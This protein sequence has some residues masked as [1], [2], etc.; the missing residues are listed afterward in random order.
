MIGERIQNYEV[1][2]LLGEGGMGAVYV[3]KHPVIDRKVAIK[4]LRRELAT[5]KAL[6]ERFINEARAANVI[7]HPNIVEIQD[8]GT[9]PDGLPYIIMELLAGESLAQRLDRVGRLG[10]EQAIHFAVQATSAL[11]AA[12]AE[13]IVHRDLKPDNLFLSPVSPATA[14]AREVLKVLDFG[15]AKV[16]RDVSSSKLTSTGSLM[17]TPTYMSPEQCRGIPG[18]IDHRTDIYAMGAIIYQMLCGRPPFVSEG[19]GDL[20]IMHLTQAPAPLRSLNPNVPEHVERAVLAALEKDKAA[21]PQTMDALQ[22]MLLAGD[23]TDEA[24]GE[25]AFAATM[26]PPDPGSFV[27]GSNPFANLRRGGTNPGAGG[28]SGTIVGIGG[29]PAKTPSTPA[30]PALQTSAKV[31]TT[32]S[33]STG[34]VLTAAG[35]DDDALDALGAS[36]A[37]RKRS[38][39]IGGAAAGLVAVVAVVGIASRGKDEGAKAGAAATQGAPA[40][41]SAGPITTPS[42]P[43]SAAAVAPPAPAAA[44]SEAP[45]PAAQPAAPEV[46][47]AAATP[48]AAAPP[49]QEP[50][51]SEAGSR[52]SRGKKG[53]SADRAPAAKAAAPVVA[54]KPTAAP[55]V[56]P[57]PVAAP[58][59]KP[60]PAPASPAETAKKAKK[61]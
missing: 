50:A 51:R 3:G 16:K 9:L 48:P 25:A 13:G 30:A 53:R 60:G 10:V 31:P 45:K 49:Q 17:G 6:I 34:Q 37:K 11:A 19:V 1:V 14:P 36:A 57:P 38:V 7:R 42:A 29:A 32:F 61:W 5:D 8:V 22:E 35:L 47:R 2:S 39:I 28:A 27:P 15:I 43:P 33:R 24:T 55:G 21:R 54:A 46:A 59:L 20:L 26:M 18:E 12:H 4:V 41:P 40:A 23:L 44:P 56:A 58:S 52:S